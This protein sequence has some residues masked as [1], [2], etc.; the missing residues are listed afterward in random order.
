M[1]DVRFASAL[2]AAELEDVT[3]LIRRVTEIDGLSPLS[4]HALLHLH[5]GADVRSIH[6]LAFQS[7][8]LAGYAHLDVTDEVAGPSAE[9]AVDPAYRRTGI[10]RML[11]QA[12]LDRRPDDRLRLWAHGEHAAA[13]Q[14]AASMGFRRSRILWQMRRS[15]L[16]PLP[17]VELPAGIR[18]TAFRPGVDEGAWLEVNAQAFA[19]HPEQG[20][21]RAEDLTVRM[22]EPWFDPEGFLMAW[23]GETLAG[24]HWTK[25]H[26]GESAHEDIGEVY[27]VAV[28]ADWRG[29]G[30]GRALTIAG[31]QHLR[32]QGLRQAM[33]YVDTEN[34]GAIRLYENLGFAHWDTDVMYTRRG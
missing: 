21:W 6:L 26:G 9:V 4:E 31:L 32:S 33:L 34:R 28:A 16:A 30:L 7:G 12:M 18:L 10:G 14:L 3:A 27:V 5:R 23:A 19:T 1:T 17:P 24:F 8:T 25:I 22:A 13:G 29:T 20:S 2:T 15:L 11:V